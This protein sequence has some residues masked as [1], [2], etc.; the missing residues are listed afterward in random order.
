MIFTI[1]TPAHKQLVISYIDNLNIEKRGYKIRIEPIATKR[2]NE[3]NRYMH[4]VFNLI[5]EETG[6]VMDRVKWY[7]KDKFLKTIELV[8]GKEITRIKS[9]TELNTIEQEEFMSEVRIDASAEL[10]I[11][12]PLPNEII[13]DDDF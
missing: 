11:F 7:Y 13:Y 12:V 4:F 5:S 8:L 10:S 6:E 1:K 2:S 9:T 3:Q